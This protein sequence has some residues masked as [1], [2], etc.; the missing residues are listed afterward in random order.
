M[1]KKILIVDDENILL[2]LLSKKFKEEG[3]EVEMASDGEEGFKKALEILPDL[4]ILDVVMPKVNGLEMLAKL[5]NNEQGKDI[6][7]IVL[8]NVK[9][10]EKIEDAVKDGASEYL[11]KVEWSLENLVKKVKSKF[12]ME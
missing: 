8:T 11:V 4:I 3:F 6:K 7:V 10:I 2:E 12:G 5:R 9:E 1:A